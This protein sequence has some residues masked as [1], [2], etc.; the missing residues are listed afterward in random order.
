MPGL[1]WLVQQPG[2]RGFP[3]WLCI[4]FVRG[5]DERAVLA[6]LGVDPDDAMAPGDPE[7]E[8]TPGITIVRSG[9]WLVALEDAVYARG[10]RPDV[11]L[12]LSAGTEVVVIYEDIGKGNNQFAHAVDGEVIT[13]VTTTMPPSWGGTQ[14]DRLRPLA[15]ELGM[16][17]E[18]GSPSDSDY[19]MGGLELLLLLAEV[20][21][22]LSLDEADLNRPLL[23]VPDQP[24]GPTPGPA[25]VRRAGRG[26]VPG[27]PAP[28]AKAARQRGHRRHHRRP[29]RVLGKRH[30]QPA[31]RDGLLDPGQDR[32]ADTRHRGATQHVTLSAYWCTPGDVLAYLAWSGPGAY[33]EVTMTGDPVPSSS[34]RLPSG[35]ARTAATCR[36]RPTG[37]RQPVTSSLLIGITAT[38]LPDSR[39][40]TPG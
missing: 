22:G 29:H 8:S 20:A 2:S 37:C 33:I 38:A 23:K 5:S 6:G 27:D 9:E 35:R 34:T 16:G 30:R 14:P 10:I 11:L 12:R 15:E 17:H 26:E 19:D 31:S 32:A 28:C 13:S 25:G 3:G 18:D 40:R 4:T 36:V 24:P 7:F 1:T 39:T 21:V